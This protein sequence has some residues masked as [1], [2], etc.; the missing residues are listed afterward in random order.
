LEQQYTRF[1]WEAEVETRTAFHLALLAQRR[2]DSAVTTAH[3]LEQVVAIT[4]ALVET[5]EESPLRLRL[6]EAE[7]AQAHAALNDAQY[8]YRAACNRLS[9][10][11]GVGVD[12]LLEPY[13]E[14]PLPKIDR[15]QAPEGLLADHPLTRA[16]Q[17]Q[18]R[19]AEAARQSAR[20]DAWPH[21]S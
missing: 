20:R 7:L 19:A 14:S 21:I 11:S 3:F 8:Q 13:G 18:V 17:S 6:A 16:L 15:I 4:R 12:E 9:L 2:V 10:P 5:G 1:Q